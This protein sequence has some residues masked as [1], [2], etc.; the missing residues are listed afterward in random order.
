MVRPFTL[1]FR[2]VCL[3]LLPG[4]KTDG[5]PYHMPPHYGLTGYKILRFSAS[6]H[7]FITSIRKILKYTL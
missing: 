6:M 7:A 3:V 2:Y 4:I 5:I 1:C